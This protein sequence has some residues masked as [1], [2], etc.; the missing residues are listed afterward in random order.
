MHQSSAISQHDCLH[1]YIARQ[2]SASFDSFIALVSMSIITVIFDEK[3]EEWLCQ[4]INPINLI[5]IM[6]NTRIMVYHGHHEISL[7]V[8]DC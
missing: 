3:Q 5:L 8:A 7:V 4:K 2:C 1:C 6:E